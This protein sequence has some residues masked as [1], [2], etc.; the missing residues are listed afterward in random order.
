MSLGSGSRCREQR[1]GLASVGGCP[2]GG[3]GLPHSVSQKENRGVSTRNGGGS[4]E[5]NVFCLAVVHPFKHKGDSGAVNLSTRCPVG[6]ADA[7]ETYSFQRISRMLER[8]TQRDRRAKSAAWDRVEVQ[9]DARAG[10]EPFSSLNPGR[11]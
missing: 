5:T 6:S 9:Q 10:R 1:V 7:A 2:P 11:D 3:A 8:E 4:G